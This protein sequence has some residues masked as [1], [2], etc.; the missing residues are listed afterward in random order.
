MGAFYMCAGTDK[1]I[2]ITVMESGVAMNLTGLDV[3]FIMTNGGHII[4]KTIDH[5]L[6]I[7]DGKA[8]VTLERSD[9]AE[10]TRGVWAYEVAVVNLDDHKDS[11]AKGSI[12]ILNSELADWPETPIDIVGE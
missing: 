1:T 5:G 10:A 9:T 12:T 7:I 6:D 8:V 2:G 11:V 4:S 3:A